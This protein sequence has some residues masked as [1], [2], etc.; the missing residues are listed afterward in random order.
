[1]TWRSTDSIETKVH[2]ASLYSIREAN[3]DDSYLQAP[4]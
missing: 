3:T 1:M 4:A 2:A